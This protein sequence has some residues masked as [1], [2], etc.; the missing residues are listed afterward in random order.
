LAKLADPAFLRTVFLF[1]ELSEPD[2]DALVL[3]LRDRRV[4]KGE[5]LFREGDA[6]HE[7]YLIREGSV[8]VSKLVTGRVEQ[9]LARMGAGEIFGEMSLFDEAPRSAT[10]QMESEGLL[11]CLD[12]DGLRRLIETRPQAAAA[13][14]FR[15]VQLFTT[16]LRATGNLVAEVTRWGLEATGM[17]LESRLPG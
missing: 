10:V 3:S 9:V 17:D 13:L 7:L 6:G 16:R 5:V 12:R 2:L 11:F 15:F 8:V 4:R 1:R 14:L